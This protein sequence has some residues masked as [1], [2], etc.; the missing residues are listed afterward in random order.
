[1]STPDTIRRADKHVV[2]CYCSDLKPEAKRLAEILEAP[3]IDPRRADNIRNYEPQAGSI[4]WLVGHG[5]EDDSMIGPKV[6]RNVAIEI[7]A[8]IAWCSV[9]MIATVVDTCSQPQ[10]RKQIV[11]SMRT[12]LGYFCVRDHN[13]LAAI[14]SNEGLND[15][16]AESKIGRISH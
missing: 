11:K 4:A 13:N 14:T 5:V 7:A 15:W 16:W 6:N 10:T 3:L 2:F 1:M 12:N 9:N 8:I